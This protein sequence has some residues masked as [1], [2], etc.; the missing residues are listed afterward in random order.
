MPNTY[1]GSGAICGYRSLVKGKIPNN[2]IVVGSPAKIVR[3]DIAWSRENIS[4]DDR[5]F[6]IIHELYRQYTDESDFN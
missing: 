1:I 2:C 3:K 4:Y 6:L 5:D